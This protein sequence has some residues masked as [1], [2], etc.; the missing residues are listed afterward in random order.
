MRRA[1]PVA[2]LRE[3]QYGRCE[4]GGWE[5]EDLLWCTLR[6]VKDLAW[7]PV[8][9]DLRHVVGRLIQRVPKRTVAGV[10]ADLDKSARHP[11]L[12]QFAAERYL[13][14]G[15]SSAELT[16]ATNGYHHVVVIGLPQTI[17]KIDIRDFFEQLG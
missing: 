2:A 3:R 16:D 1:Q 17:Q 11:K 5:G 8:G 10:R 14:S 13:F 7:P 15:V 12:V 9:E 4:L 6:R